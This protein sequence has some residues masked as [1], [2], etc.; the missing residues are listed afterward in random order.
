MK[1]SLF[2]FTAYNYTP[3]DSMK[4]NPV[5]FASIAAPRD[6]EMKFIIFEGRDKKCPHASIDVL[7]GDTYRRTGVTFVLFRGEH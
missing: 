5:R 3:G 1:V 2:D 7:C 6:K 4:V